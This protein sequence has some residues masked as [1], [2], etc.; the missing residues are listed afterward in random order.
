MSDVESRIRARAHALW[1]EQGCPAGKELEHWEAAR[2]EVLQED[3]HETPQELGIPQENDGQPKKAP[4]RSA[5][6]PKKS[7]LDSVIDTG[8]Q[9]D[10]SPT[11]TAKAPARR[12]PGKPA[13]APKGETADAAANA[14]A[15]T[16]KRTT[17]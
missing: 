11:A 2:R 3:T 1:E 17:R 8:T 16:R 14:P 7:A 10:E 9:A 15:K 5:A 12:K 13:A 6:K 4:R